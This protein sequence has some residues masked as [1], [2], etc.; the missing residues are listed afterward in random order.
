MFNIADLIPLGTY[1]GLSALPQFREALDNGR[2]CCASDS[3]VRSVNMLT[4]R[5]SG[6]VWL[7]TVGPKGGW[8]RRW[9]F[10]SP[11]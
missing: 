7:I 3:A 2:S 1:A 5:A 11:H 4:L 10:G 8:K 6:E 9:N